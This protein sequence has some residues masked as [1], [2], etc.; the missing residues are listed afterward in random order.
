[1]AVRSKKPGAG[2]PQHERKRART[3]KTAKIELED[4]DEEHD[5][6]HVADLIARGL[7]KPGKGGPSI[8]ELLRPGPRVPGATRLVLEERELR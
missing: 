5:R 4:E 1:M 8:P 3:P 7:L 6:A 2:T